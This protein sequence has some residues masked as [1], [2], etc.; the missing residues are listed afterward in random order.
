MFTKYDG[1]SVVWKYFELNFVPLGWE[2]GQ[3][4]WRED[5]DGDTAY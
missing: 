3:E 2:W 1:K 4:Q 5:G